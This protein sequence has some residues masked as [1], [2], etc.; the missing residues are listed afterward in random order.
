MGQIGMPEIIVIFIV[1]AM[2]AIPICLALGLIW[3]FSS[4]KKEPQMAPDPGSAQDR[5]LELESLRSKGLISDAE[6]EEKRRK[7]LSGI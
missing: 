1:L 7:I 4:R 5:L 2:I 3:Y 6:H